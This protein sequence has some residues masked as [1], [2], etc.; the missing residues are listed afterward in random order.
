MKSIDSEVNNFHQK[1]AKSMHSL[2][3]A[4]SEGFEAMDK[5]K[6]D[7]TQEEGK[8]EEKAEVEPVQE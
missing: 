5:A 8:G 2:M 1:M 4:F 7:E 6:Q 3:K